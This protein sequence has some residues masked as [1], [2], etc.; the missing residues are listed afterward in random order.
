[1][2]PIITRPPSPAQEECVREEVTW[3]MRAG[4]WLWGSGCLAV[5]ITSALGW[6]IRVPPVLV[7]VPAGLFALG[8]GSFCVGRPGLATPGRAAACAFAAMMAILSAT[9]LPLR[10]TFEGCRPAMDTAAVKA[11]GGRLSPGTWAGCYRIQSAEV[12]G[13]GSIFLWTCVTAA[14][15]CGFVKSKIPKIPGTVNEVDLGNGWRCLFF[16][17]QAQ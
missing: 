2:Q 7:F 1:M 15:R 11:A 5:F 6:L 3:S 8:A 10:A 13:D 14:G 12:D 9:Q 4:A 16:R 17:S